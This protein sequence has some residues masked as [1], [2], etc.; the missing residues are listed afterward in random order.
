MKLEKLQVVV[1]L[2]LL[3]F[4]LA[5]FSVSCVRKHDYVWSEYAISQ[6]RISGA[7]E[8]IP[9]KRIDLVNAQPDSEIRDIGNVGPHHYYGSLN[10][11][12]ESIIAQLSSELETRNITANSNTDRTIKIK[13]LNARTIRGMWVIRAEMNVEV[14]AGDYYRVIT[15]ENKTP[16]TVPR[17]YNGAIA[18]AV[19]E[20]LNDPK[21]IAYINQ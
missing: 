9:G 18:I 16:D 21:I 20:I 11:L 13:V 10:K 5:A 6:E 7:E 1:V 19:I 3:L 12:T 8:L 14:Q 2:F 17:A 4:V 15:A